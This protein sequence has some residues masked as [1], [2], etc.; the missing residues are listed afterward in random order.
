M[1]RAALELQDQLPDNVSVTY[2]A[3]RSQAS[4]A[5]LFVEYHKF[6]AVWILQ[7]LG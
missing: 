3:V 7:V 6:L 5:T 4:F 1:R 2:D